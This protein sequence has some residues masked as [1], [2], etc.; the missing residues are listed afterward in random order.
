MQ[1]VVPYPEC[2]MSLSTASKRKTSQGIEA[3]DT[4][5]QFK[6]PLG[7][8]RRQSAQST[9]RQKHL[10]SLVA[11]NNN[12]LHPTWSA[13]RLSSRTV[14]EEGE[15]AWKVLSTEDLTQLQEDVKTEISP[16]G[17]APLSERGVP[18]GS[19]DPPQPPRQS[20]TKYHNQWYS[21]ITPHVRRGS[22]PGE[23]SVNTHVGRRANRVAL[24]GPSWY[25]QNRLTR[26]LDAAEKR[27]LL[28]RFRLR[29]PPHLEGPTM[30]DSECL[31]STCTNEEAPPSP[32]SMS[33]VT[34]R[35]EEETSIVSDFTS[36]AVESFDFFFH[37]PWS[38]PLMPAQV[39]L[40]KQTGNLHYVDNCCNAVT[41]S[42]QD[43][44]HVMVSSLSETL[45]LDLDS[46]SLPLVS[47]CVSDVR[48]LISLLVWLR[49]TLFKQ[50]KELEVTVDETMEDKILPSL[51][52]E[53]QLQVGPSPRFLR[54]GPVFVSSQTRDECQNGTRRRGS[55]APNEGC[56]WETAVLMLKP[57]HLFLSS[58]LEDKPFADWSLSPPSSI[59]FKAHAQSE[60][61]AL[62]WLEIRGSQGRRRPPVVLVGLRSPEEA[63]SWAA[64]LTQAQNGSLPAEG[65]EECPDPFFS[66]AP[67]PIT[68]LISSCGE[69]NNNT[70]MSGHR[71]KH[72]MELSSREASEETAGADIV[73]F[74]AQ[75]EICGDFL[76]AIRYSFAQSHRNCSRE[77]PPSPSQPSGP[78]LRC[79]V[80]GTAVED[81]FERRLRKSVSVLRR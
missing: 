44:R 77:S 51:L 19:D 42:A 16:S 26:P 8:P 57:D 68:A 31:S 49:R 39:A 72:R 27:E 64:C 12:G 11:A 36:V 59:R 35:E 5:E 24:Q 48:R 69:A 81:V 55:G 60:E 75:E 41:I 34:I 73:L 18:E 40:D 67:T 20:S 70:K 63:E 58:S 47:P 6:R 71:G 79:Q 29:L 52:N 13:P 14:D 7:P 56:C 43:V 22:C 37:E 80:L 62:T 45:V 78:L 23:S 4:P 17:L 2:P 32:L 1:P 28:E 38:A 61:A 50:E 30:V 21:S 25:I 3:L 66:S 65:T 53:R 10:K 54:C 76:E 74:F 15:I 33:A 9:P 46:G